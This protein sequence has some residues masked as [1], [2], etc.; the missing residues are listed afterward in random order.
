MDNIIYT[1]IAF[2]NKI[3]EEKQARIMFKKKD[4]ADRVMNCTLDF[5]KIPEHDRQ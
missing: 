5:D 1:A 4:G 2:L 3:K